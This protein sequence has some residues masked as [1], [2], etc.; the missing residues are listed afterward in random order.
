MADKLSKE[1]AEVLSRS[2]NLYRSYWTAIHN[3]MRLFEDLYATYR[4]YRDPYLHPYKYNISKPIALALVQQYIS[5]MVNS[6]FEKDKLVNHTPN[7][8][9]KDKILNVG[10]MEKLAKQTERAV[11]GLWQLPETDFYNFIYD[12]LFDQSVYGVSYINILPAFDDEKTEDGQLRRKYIHPKFLTRDPLEVVPNPWSTTISN[13]NVFLKEITDVQTVE[14]RVETDGYRKESVELIKDKNHISED[15][16][17]QLNVDTQ[18]F[19]MIEYAADQAR[20]HNRVLLLHHFENGHI[21]TIGSSCAIL[22]SSKVP[23]TLL[24]PLGNEIVGENGKKEERIL[25]PYS[26]DIWDSLSMNAPSRE[27]MGIGIAEIARQYQDNANLRGSMKFEN[28]ELALQKVLLVN[29]LFDLDVENLLF[30]AGN[31]ITTND[32]NNSMKVFEMGN[33]TTDIYT[34]DAIEQAEAERAGGTMP[35]NRGELPGGRPTALGLGIASRGGQGRQSM[36]LRRINNLFRSMAVK[37]L[38]QIRDYWTKEQYE[39]FIGEEDA[40]LYNL[41]TQEIMRSI[42]IKISASSLELTKEQRDFTM[43]EIWK[44]STQ[45]PFINME[46]LTKELFTRL[47]PDVN[48]D[49][50]FG[51]NTLQQQLPPTQN[52]GNQ[53]GDPIS[54]EIVSGGPSNVTVDNLLGGLLNGESQ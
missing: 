6:L 46:E 48:P 8:I 32:I 2:L 5:T 3:R 7:N 41:T 44:G 33:I 16:R 10:D 13:K 26:Y 9:N 34:E 31:V 21:T 30:G 1:D 42:N 51:V 49:R 27:V 14:R 45:L 43:L 12:V 29:P 20:K 35:I 39:G 11:N 18:V 17:R 53:P 47:I 50:F 37:T 28:I 52:P 19:N 54:N 23:T 38:I 36:N 24:D 25:K 15:L 40:G 4:F 22:K